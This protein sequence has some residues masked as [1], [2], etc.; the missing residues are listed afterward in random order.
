V[1]VRNAP[2]DKALVVEFANLVAETGGDTAAAEKALE[3]LI[4]STSFDPDLAQVQKNLSARKTLDAGYGAL[5][6]GGGSY[7]DI[8]RNKDEAVTLEQEHRVQKSED[9]AANLISEYETRLTDEPDNVK[10]MRSLAELYTQK[11]QFDRALELY[12]RIKN[13]GSGGDATL[14]RA[15]ADTTV[16]KMDFELAQLNPFA[17]DHADQVARIEAAKTGFRL[18][19][20]QQRAEK[21]PTDL[22]I[23]FELGQLYLQ[24][25]KIGEAIGE[26]QKAQ[27]SPHKRIAAMSGLAQ[28]FARR[29]MNDSAVRTLEN[30]IKEKAAFDE[31]KKDLIY[32]LGCVLEKMGKKAEAIQQFL[33]IYENDISYR[34]IGAKVD[35]HYAA[36]EKGGGSGPATK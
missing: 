27:Q 25:G 26:F 35:A 24:A 33:I 1:M 15:M 34:D 7:R 20:C 36:Q 11:S 3:E 21:Y 16:R 14:D 17:T 22:A 18:A 19:D 12:Q 10:M 9:T 6:G 8:L 5:E 29:G 31:E 2:K 23:R 30:A 4:R 13:A 32:Q 28:C